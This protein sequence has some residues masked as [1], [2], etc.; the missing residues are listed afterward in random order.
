MVWRGHYQTKL[1]K[2]TYKTREQ[3]LDPDIANA[4]LKRFAKWLHADGQPQPSLKQKLVALL[5][6]LD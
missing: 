4:A 5:K 3:S 6:D 2:S 1:L